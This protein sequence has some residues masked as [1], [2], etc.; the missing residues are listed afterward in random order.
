MSDDV[1]IGG[2]DAF[3]S[4]ASGDAELAAHLCGLLEKSAITVWM[5]PRDVPAGA[6]YAD[7][8]VRAINACLRVLRQTNFAAIGFC[9]LACQRHNFNVR[10]VTARSGDGN[11]GA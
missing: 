7:A 8:I 2:R 3:L 9:L 11:I 4:Y 6:N 5:A 1:Q 10:R